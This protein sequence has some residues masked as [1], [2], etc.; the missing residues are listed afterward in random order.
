[1]R[2]L[3][4]PTLKTYLTTFPSTPHPPWKQKKLALSQSCFCMTALMHTKSRH[5]ESISSSFISP[6][7][8]IRRGA[9]ILYMNIQKKRKWP[10]FYF[11]LEKLQHITWLML[12]H[13]HDKPWLPNQWLNESDKIAPMLAW[14]LLNH[15]F[16]TFSHL[17]N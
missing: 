17:I 14:G 2:T 12:V 15:F 7:A 4:F 6:F 8:I 16:T 11:N 9:C 10:F 13:A 1:M 5:Y 3:F